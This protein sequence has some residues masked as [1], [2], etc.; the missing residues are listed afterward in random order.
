MSGY[1]KILDI[2]FS[3]GELQDCKTQSQH[4]CGSI[5]PLN[6]RGPHGTV[7]PQDHSA[8]RPLAF[9]EKNPLM[10]YLVWLISFEVNPILHP[11]LGLLARLE[12]ELWID[13]VPILRDQNH[14]LGYPTKTTPSTVLTCARDT[15]NSRTVWV[16]TELTRD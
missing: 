6:H 9:A 14:D 4:T 7:F 2:R 8:Q 10:W 5:C 16:R 11:P 1:S 15:L 3:L 12:G 13:T